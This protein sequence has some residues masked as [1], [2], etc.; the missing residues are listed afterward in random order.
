MYKV[1]HGLLPAYI[2]DLFVRKGPTHL[3]R[4]GDFLFLDWAPHAMASTLLDISGRSYCQKEIR[5]VYLFLYKK[6]RKLN[7]SDI[8]SNNNNCV[9][10]GQY[11]YF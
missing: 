5:P 1:K 11:N 9:L 4:N 10:F 2:S 3:L 7:L 6:S 8:L